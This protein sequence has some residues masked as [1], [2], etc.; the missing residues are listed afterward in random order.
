MSTRTLFLLGLGAIFASGCT[1]EPPSDLD[2]DEPTGNTDNT[3]EP[4]PEPTDEPT[5]EP[6][7]DTDTD[8]PWDGAGTL[9]TLT[10]LRTGGIFTGGELLAIRNVVV[11]AVGRNGFIVQ[12]P[13]VTENGG[14]YVLTF[15]SGD[16]P[17]LG[18]IVDVV[19]EYEEYSNNSG[20]APL[21][22]LAELKVISQVAGSEWIFQGTGELPAPQTVDIATLSDAASAEA[23]ESMLVQVSNPGALEV[24]S[25]PNNFGEWM[26]TTTGAGASVMVGDEFYDLSDDYVITPGD[27]FDSLRS[28][29]FYSFGNYKLEPTAGEDLVGYSGAEDTGNPDCGLPDDGNG[30]P[31]ATMSQIRE[32]GCASNGDTV[33]VNNLIV[34]GVRTGSGAGFFAQTDGAITPY[35]GAF[36]FTATDAG[37]PAV[38]DIVNVTA[39]IGEY[40]GLLQLQAT[41]T[42]NG[43]VTVVSSGNAAPSPITLTL[44]NL[45]DAATAETYESMLVT[46]SEGTP[47]EVLS[48]ATGSA[49][50]EFNVSTSSSSDEAT[51]GA[52]LYNAVDG[53]SIAAGGTLSS[54][55]GPLNYSFSTYK[56]EPRDA[57]DVDNYQAP[58]LP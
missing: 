27:T 42:N 56:V 49:A 43:T 9:T 5:D 21:E 11:T 3:D 47:L 2:T 55:T 37:L 51:I 52:R 7:G 4:G 18:D 29:V 10:E 13:T 48:L 30:N 14:I 12:D 41:A 32:E 58:A 53:V 8:D 35:N 15:E 54:V 44:A 20:T 39:P 50:G 46:L 23:Y 25:A 40:F 33:T 19:G 31:V 38:G 16:K 24:D 34:T 22:T 45:N 28:I 1:R 36:V 6:T 57:T 26:F 17:Q